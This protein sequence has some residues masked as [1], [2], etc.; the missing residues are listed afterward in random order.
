MFPVESVELNDDMIGRGWERITGLRQ[1]YEFSVKSGI[2]P[3]C[4]GLA[5][6]MCKDT[7][8][9]I[10]VAYEKGENI[11]EV[12]LNDYIVADPDDRVTKWNM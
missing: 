1:M 12:L 6:N 10:C 3:K 5:C 4:S 8:Q 11:N 2:W 7:Y 9:K